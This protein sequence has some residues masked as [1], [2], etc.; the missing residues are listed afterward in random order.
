LEGFR[1]ECDDDD[2]E[3]DDDEHDDEDDEDDEDDDEH[4]DDEYDE[5]DDD[6]EDTPIETIV[7]TILQTD[8]TIAATYMSYLCQDQ[9]KSMIASFEFCRN[10]PNV[11]KSR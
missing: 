5:D 10:A 2:E 6:D 1:P 8:S 9:D 11:N 3:Y 7:H 4:E